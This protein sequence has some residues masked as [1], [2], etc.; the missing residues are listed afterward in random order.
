ME[1]ITKIIQTNP[2]KTNR[3]RHV[4]GRVCF[5]EKDD[6]CILDSRIHDKCFCVTPSL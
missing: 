6:I 5:H 3:P 2:P 4:L 1:R